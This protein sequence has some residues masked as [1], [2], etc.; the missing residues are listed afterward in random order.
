MPIHEILNVRRDIAQ[1]KIAPAA[2][3]VGHVFGNIFGPAFGRV[4][5]HHT[6]RP[7]R[8]MASNWNYA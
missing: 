7:A 3:L 2:Q 8:S 4:E 5:S 1:L 6:D